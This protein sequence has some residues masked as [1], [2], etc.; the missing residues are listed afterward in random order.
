[1]RAT[2]ISCT[3]KP[4]PE[5]SDTEALALVVDEALRGHSVDTE[6]IRAVDHELKPG[7]ETD[8]GAGD[9]WP[10]IHDK[11]LASEI[12]VIATQPGSGGRRASPSG[13]SSGWTRCS[14]R[15]T[16]RAGPSPTTGSRAR[17]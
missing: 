3:P 11:L 12:L 9:E 4:S 1:M 13:C 2:I 6:L 15:P 16:T 7:I 17:S 14:P 10:P 8:M 5:T